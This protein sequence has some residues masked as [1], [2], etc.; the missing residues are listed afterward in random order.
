LATHLESGGSA[1]VEGAAER[2]LFLEFLW[3]FGGVSEF[4]R[5]L[6]NKGDEGWIMDRVDSDVGE[7]SVA[8]ARISETLDLN[9]PTQM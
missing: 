5:M 9:A 7:S 2:F 3:A 1:W 8:G 6:L 4:S